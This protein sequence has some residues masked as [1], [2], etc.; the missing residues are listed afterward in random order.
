MATTG[1]QPA[2]S[3]C[4]GIFLPDRL[5]YKDHVRWRGS[6]KRLSGRCCRLWGRLTGNRDREFQGEQLIIAGKLEAYFAASRKGT[7]STRRGLRSGGFIDRRRSFY[8]V[9]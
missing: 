5:M 4:R 8:V 1:R 6:C 9:A 2:S 7:P 3:N